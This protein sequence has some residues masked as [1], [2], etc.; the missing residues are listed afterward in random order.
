MPSKP[1][2]LRV[3]G[4]DDAEAAIGEL[5]HGERTLMGSDLEPTLIQTYTIQDSL[6]AA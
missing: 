4:A 5:I 1:E 6:F 2:L 3:A